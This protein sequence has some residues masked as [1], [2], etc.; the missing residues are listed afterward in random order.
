MVNASLTTN[1]GWGFGNAIS[2]KFDSPFQDGAG[3]PD[4]TFR[5]LVG[6]KPVMSV[7][8]VPFYRQAA[9]WR[10]AQAGANSRYF[11][12]AGTGIGDPTENL[13]TA[14]TA[15]A[16]SFAGAASNYMQ[17]AAILAAQIGVNRV[18]QA[19]TA[20]SVGKSTPD[21]LSD[22]VSYVGT[23][24]SSVDFGTDGPS[25]VGGFR[26]LSGTALTDA[27]KA[28]MFGIT[29]NLEFID[30]V[31]V[32]GNTLTASTS[33]TDA[34]DVFSL[35]LSP[36][37]GSWTFTLL[38][39]VNLPT[40]GFDPTVTLNLSSLMQGVKST[41]Q[42]VALS[43]PIKITIHGDEASS[44]GTGTAGDI[45]QGGLVYT[46]ATTGTT[47]KPAYAPPTNPLTGRGYAPTSAAVQSIGATLNLLIG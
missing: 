39:P 22:Q 11:G 43:N 28:A 5:F 29:S 15:A 27:F 33:G 38:N 16:N 25:A 41:G 26:F 44:R 37:S 7:G 1:S 47:T 35:T 19:A 40:K 46:P 32:S 8:F 9:S 45:H 10:A 6:S 42:T 3:G 13:I 17:S 23:L 2:A 12:G 30:T 24:S 36:V 18:N 34:H 14:S 20:S 31:S 21:Q 4:R